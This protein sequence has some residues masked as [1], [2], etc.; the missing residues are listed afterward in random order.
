MFRLLVLVLCVAP[1]MAGCGTAIATYCLETVSELLPGSTSSIAQ[2]FGLDVD[3]ATGTICAVVEGVSA[4]NYLGVSFPITGLLTAGDL[5]T[6]RNASPNYFLWSGP[7][8]NEVFEIDVS[9]QVSA[10]VGYTVSAPDGAVPTIQIYGYGSLAQPSDFHFATNI[11]V[12]GS[13][14]NN[15]SV[16]PTSLD[17]ASLVVADSQGAD[18][19]VA[20]G[21]PPQTIVGDPQFRGLRGQTYQVHGLSNQIYNLVS[22]PQIQLN[23]RFVY[24]EDGACPAALRTDCWTHPGTYIGELGLLHMFMR[25]DLASLRVLAGPAARGFAA[26]E[27]NGIPVGVSQ[28]L[29]HGDFNVHYHS[30]HLVAFNTTQFHVVLHNSDMFMNQDLAARVPL[31]RIDAHGLFGQTSRHTVYD[32]Q[33]RYIEGGVDD[34]AIGDNDI[35]GADFAYNRFKP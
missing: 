2:N 10:P 29:H 5:V 16:V 15:V 30:P 26:V 23:A 31:S 19:V 11:I 3:T 24:L 8:V 25:H 1:V 13:G 33:I 9:L 27:F 18:C 17:V 34:Y 7:G 21:A 6:P 4:F 12:T 22:T 32:N 14:V 35:F 28:T 20:S